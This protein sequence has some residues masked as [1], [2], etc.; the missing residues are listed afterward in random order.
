MMSS[1]SQS[2]ST[3]ASPRY[4]EAADPSGGQEQLLQ[5]VLAKSIE[6]LTVEES[7][8][9]AALEAAEA[10]ARRHRGAELTLV[11]VA[12]ELVEAVLSP[13]FHA[14]AASSVMI[15]RI[16]ETLWEDPVARPRL[17]QLW[18]RLRERADRVG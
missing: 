6:A 12:V 10:V 1:S 3:S 2:G 5:A 11:P 4:A 8:D 17:E 13:M 7:P 14:S 9:P 18:N 16:S 15:E